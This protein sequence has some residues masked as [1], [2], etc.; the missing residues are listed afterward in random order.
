MAHR[1]HRVDPYDHPRVRRGQRPPTVPQGPHIAH[2]TQ[3]G[4]AA[5]R[6]VRSRTPAPSR[7][8]ERVDTRGPEAPVLTAAAL[9][10]TV[11]LAAADTGSRRVS[12]APNPFNLGV[13]GRYRVPDRHHALPPQA[14]RQVPVS[15]RDG[16]LRQP[17]HPSHRGD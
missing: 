7:L 2:T 10:G 13:D 8:R 14:A 9:Q 5:H 1:Q 12:Y 15:R 11:H 4:D 6:N 16:L 17:D 3:H